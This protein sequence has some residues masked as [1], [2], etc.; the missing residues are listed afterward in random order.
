M[1]IPF[2]RGIFNEGQAFFE[3][4]STA[5]KDEKQVLV[6]DMTNE[7]SVFCIIDLVASQQANPERTH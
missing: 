4:L 2:S 7:G 3:F 5:F 1:R 6:S